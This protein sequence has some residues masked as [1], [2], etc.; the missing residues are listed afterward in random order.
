MKFL[1]AFALAAS[2]P[3][4]AADEYVFASPT[5][6]EFRFHHKTLSKS[7]QNK[8]TV[9]VGYWTL[10]LPDQSVVRSRVEVTGCNDNLGT[11]TTTIM[12]SDKVLSHVWV[13]DGVAVYDHVAETQCL[14]WGILSVRP[15]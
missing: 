14:F 1:L 2:P 5:G 7:T 6:G 15:K 13:G 8:Q 9:I 3:A 11:I 4:V 10:T 12:G